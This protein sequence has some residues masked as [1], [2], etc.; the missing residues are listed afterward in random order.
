MSKHLDALRLLDSLQS[1]SVA[2]HREQLNTLMQAHA[3]SF[4]SEVKACLKRDA[5]EDA[6]KAQQRLESFLGIFQHHERI[7]S[8]IQFVCDTVTSAIDF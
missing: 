1:E 7:S 8:Y 4:C 6:K 5:L 2:N 3:Q